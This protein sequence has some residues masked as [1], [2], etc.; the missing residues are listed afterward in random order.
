M[1]DKPA[2]QIRSLRADELAIAPAAVLPWNDL[3]IARPPALRLP[4]AG[5]GP[6]VIRVELGLPRPKL[7]SYRFAPPAQ[8]PAAPAAARSGRRVE[9]SA[10]DAPPQPAA[11]R[12]TRIARPRDIV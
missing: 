10:A 2:S 9:A 4:V 7:T 5:T 1:M 8:T 3:R 12:R 11:V 6:A